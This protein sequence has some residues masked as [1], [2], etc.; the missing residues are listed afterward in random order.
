VRVDLGEMYFKKGVSRVMNASG[1]DAKG[2]RCTEIN[3]E[4][5]YRKLP[6]R[7]RI[8]IFERERSKND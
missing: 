6:K 7:D 1:S 4:Q 5:N 3:H 8:T 2:P